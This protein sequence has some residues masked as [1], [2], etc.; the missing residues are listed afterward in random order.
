MITGFAG[1]MLPAVQAII[2]I[3]TTETNAISTGGMALCGIKFPATMTGANVSFEMCDT[4]G[5]TYVPVRNSAGLLSYALT[6]ST[7]L[8]VDPKDF[9]GIA[10]L[11]IKSDATEAAARTLLCSLKG[12]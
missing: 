6:V 8:A 1:N 4:L 7:Y 5:G 10:F 3:S 2:P 9:Q 12:L 11:K